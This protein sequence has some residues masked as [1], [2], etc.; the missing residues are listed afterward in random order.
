MNNK[1]PNLSADE[2][3]V[4]FRTPPRHELS[5]IT[6]GKRQLFP[7]KEYRDGR[8][9]I[10]TLTSFAV[11][12]GRP[13]RTFWRT[14]CSTESHCLSPRAINV[15]LPG[16]FSLEKRPRE[17]AE[18]HSAMQIGSYSLGSSN[19]KNSSKKPR[20]DDVREHSFTICAESREELSPIRVD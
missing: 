9:L 3:G 10:K 7:E 11:T 1:S 19:H 20:S 15:I 4:S 16:N 14:T 2:S 8:G 18:T 17:M 12:D 13:L 6:D 5:D